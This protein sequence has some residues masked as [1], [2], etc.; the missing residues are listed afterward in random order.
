MLGANYFGTIYFGQ[1]YPA[2]PVGIPTWVTPLNHATNVSALTPLVFIIPATSSNIHFEIQIDTANTFDTVNL[3]TYKSWLD[4]TG[5]EYYNG[6]SWVAIP[7][8]GVPT[9][10]IGNQARYTVTPNLST[11]LWY[12]RI[13]G[14][15]IY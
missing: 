12:R 15:I 5:W 11:G 9:A 14:R 4:Q 10:Y 13:R 2:V 8:T 6:S 1:N 3:T 7:S